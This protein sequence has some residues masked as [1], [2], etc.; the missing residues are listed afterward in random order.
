MKYLMG[1]SHISM[2]S[3]RQPGLPK[4]AVAAE[5]KTEAKDT[6]M[7]ELVI[8]FCD[9]LKYIYIYKYIYMDTSNSIL[10]TLPCCHQKQP[11]KQ[12]T[13]TLEHTLD[14]HTGGG[15]SSLLRPAFEI[16]GS[17]AA[18]SFEP[19]PLIAF[20]Q[21]KHQLTELWRSE[22]SFLGRAKRMAPKTPRNLRNLIL[23]RNLPQNHGKQ[24][25]HI[26]LIETIGVLYWEGHLPQ[27]VEKTMTGFISLGHDQLDWVALKSTR[28]MRHGWPW[29]FPHRIHGTER[30]TYI[31]DTKST[32]YM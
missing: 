12:K 11:N 21:L 6:T 9:V 18:K 8:D 24:I 10:K 22:C 13:H 1:P 29:L 31:Y 14:T 32:I 4:D 30:F 19:K 2:D 16:L 17:Q 20:D 26:Q 23:G 28:I 27:F 7:V 25:G 5:P 15:D 3:L